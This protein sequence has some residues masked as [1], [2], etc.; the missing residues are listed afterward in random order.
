ML[1]LSCLFESEAVYK[2]R[3]KEREALLN[4]GSYASVYSLYDN[5]SHLP[6]E[7]DTAMLVHHSNLFCGDKL[8]SHWTQCILKCIHRFTY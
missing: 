1:K 3:E 4:H 2:N 8:N 7:K 6:H 5:I